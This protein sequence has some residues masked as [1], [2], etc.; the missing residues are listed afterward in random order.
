MSDFR[1]H[2]RETLQKATPLRD[3]ISLLR[4]YAPQQ[5]YLR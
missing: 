3:F 1:N 4:R 5:V 2:T